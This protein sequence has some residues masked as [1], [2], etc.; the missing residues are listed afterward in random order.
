MTSS[1]PTRAALC[2]LALALAPT[3][4]ADASGIEALWGG[5]WGDN[6]IIGRLIVLVILALGAAGVGSALHHL[7]RYGRE[8]ARLVQ[9]RANLEQWRAA[10]A[11]ASAE[12]E[13]ATGADGAEDGTAARELVGIDRLREGLPAG[14]LIGGR[15]DLIESL[16]ERRLTVDVALVQQL[17]AARDEAARGL[18]LPAFAA[19]N[20]MLLGILGTFAGLAIMVQQIH[21]GLP[22]AGAAVNLDLF[23]QAFANLRSVLGG[24][25]TA[26]STSLAGMSC[27]LLCT[28]L[29]FRLRRRQASFF[30]RLERFTV[31]ELLPATVPAY[32]DEKLLERVSEQLDRSFGR[33]DEIQRLNHRT[34]EDLTGLQ[35]GFTAMIDEIR[36]ITRGEAARDLDRVIDELEK[37]N[38]SVVAVV[39]QIP[40][41]IATAERR[42]H[43][44]VAAVERLVSPI[45][46]ATPLA[47]GLLS[48]RNLLIA[49]ATLAVLL[50]ATRF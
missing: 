24:M 38:R 9:L 37:T 41:L 31:A 47:G 27:A 28:T 12:D 14:G 22:T 35:R 10:R 18:A 33:L 44:M 46:A 23:E 13:T 6:P 3:L 32:D 20:S 40:R 2:A 34:L 5:L 7:R 8:E 29:D 50:V 42:G 16:R 21:L 36:T 30:E 1:A 25:K 4:T 19:T 39:E 11:A 26:F 48:P 49:L 43:E 15:L 45:G 17:A